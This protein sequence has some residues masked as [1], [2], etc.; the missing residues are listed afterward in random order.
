[1]R[2]ITDTLDNSPQETNLGENPSYSLGV[3]DFT[4]YCRGRLSSTYTLRLLDNSMSG[5]KL[6]DNS[7]E[8]SKLVGGFNLAD[9]SVY[10]SK[11]VDNSVYGLKLVDNSVA[12]SKLVNAVAVITENAYLM[13]SGSTYLLVSP[14]NNPKLPATPNF[15]DWVKIATTGFSVE[16]VIDGNGNLVS[17]IGELTFFGSLYGWVALS[18][19]SG[20]APFMGTVHADE[21]VTVPADQTVTINAT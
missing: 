7:I 1:M 14:A 9:N 11:L 17:G 20:T 15:G 19:S 18:A 21:I 8:A 3:D 2:D 13:S 10:G 4:I 5:S 6:V 16:P 12:V